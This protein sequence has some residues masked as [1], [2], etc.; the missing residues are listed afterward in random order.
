MVSSSVLSVQRLKQ[1]QDLSSWTQWRQS[2][3][4]SLRRLREDAQEWLSSLELWRGDIHLIEGKTTI[5][6]N[7]NI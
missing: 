7:E 3:R 2:T 5:L 6:L 1:A 4:R